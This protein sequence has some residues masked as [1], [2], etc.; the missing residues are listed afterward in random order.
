M[1]DLRSRGEQLLQRMLG[2]DATF[3]PGQWEAISEVVERRSRVLIV[4]KTGWGKSLV[5][6]LATRLLRD[7]GAGPTLLISPLL[8][9]MRNQIEMAECLRIRPFTINSTNMSEWEEVE[10]DLQQDKCDVLLISPERLANPRF[11]DKTLPIFHRKRG[12]GMLVVD[13]AHCI[14]DWGH[15]FRPDYRRIGRILRGLPRSVP[16]LATT[17]TANDRVVADVAHQLGDG[18]RILRGPLARRSLRLQVIK[19]KDQAER[20]AWLAQHVPGI[21][22][23][24]IIYCL[25]VADCERVSN[26]LSRQH[27]EAPAYHARL[28]NEER[29]ER[30]Q[31]L[32]RNEVKALVATVALGM[33]FDK[34]DLG[35]VIHYQRPGSVVAYYQQIGRAGRALE[36]AYAILLNGKEDDEIQEYFIRTAFP[37]VEEMG[38]I[39]ELLDR[40]KSPEGLSMTEIQRSVNLPWGR[41]EK[42]LRFLEVEGAVIQTSRRYH[43]TANPWKPD[44]DRSTHV[45]E[46]RWQELER[47]HGFVETKGCLMEYIARELDDPHAGPCGRCA[48]CAGMILSPFVDS[49]HLQKAKRFLKGYYLMIPPRKIWPVGAVENRS[50]KI[51]EEMQNAVG[52]ALCV[53]GDAGWGETVAAGKYRDGHFSDEL[54]DASARLIMRKWKPS[55]RPQ[56]VT[57]VPSL[58]HPHLVSRF[59]F[60]LAKALH[61]PYRPALV[62]ERETPP[63]KEMQN[64]AQ[65]AANIVSALTVDTSKVMPGPVLLVDD[66]VDSRWTFTVCGILLREAGSDIVYPFALACVTEMGYVQWNSTDTSKPARLSPSSVLKSIKKTVNQGW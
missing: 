50:G 42:C 60:R 3:R 52:R 28:S 7:A 44:R 14:S 45:T 41:I 31:R 43:R 24:G 30:E 18:I 34:P 62:K 20:L 38:Y 6:F 26:W 58:R 35:F 32:L 25:T 56:W 65:Q 64:S 51:P 1:T 22:G 63:Q 48:N 55:P 29:V 2:R 13:E 40:N 61:L 23:S 8:S 17:A 12:I 66:I 15:D 59:A 16:I 5:Y 21:P 46:L 54:V 19:L 11:L 39:V 53:Y 10:G 4:Q 57:S 33:G 49:N 37:A 9:L 36:N 27:I 47:I